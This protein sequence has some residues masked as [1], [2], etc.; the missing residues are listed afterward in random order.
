[1]AR[2]SRAD[3]SAG[4]I[5]PGYGIGRASAG[6]KRAMRALPLFLSACLLAACPAAE[7]EPTATPAMAPPLEAP[8]PPRSP[9][10]GFVPPALPPE[11]VAAAIARGEPVVIIDVRAAE[12]YADAH[13]A[14]AVSAPWPGLEASDAG[15]PKDKL[16][17]LYCACADEH[18]SNEAALLLHDKH[19][20]TRLAALKGG[21]D[22]WKQEKRAIVRKPEALP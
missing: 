22:A 15:L 4:C 13:I 21:I 18:V 14:G 12:A 17:V 10:S 1:M 2:R 20:F 11:T 8:S 6:N 16:L 5:R 3:V 19:G 7:P 9:G